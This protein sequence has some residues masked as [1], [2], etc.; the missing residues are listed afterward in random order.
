MIQ[1]HLTATE[2]TQKILIKKKVNK[3]KFKK[4]MR[5]RNNLRNVPEMV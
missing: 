4:S 5:C 1:K 3:Q 2:L